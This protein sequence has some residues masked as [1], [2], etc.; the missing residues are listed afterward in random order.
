MSLEGRKGDREKGRK[1]HS[2][3]LKIC[4]TFL[5]LSLSPSLP[6][7]AEIV[8]RILAVVNDEIITQRE[9][10]EKAYPILLSLPAPPSDADLTQIR[11]NILVELVKSRLVVQAAKEKRILLDRQEVES[12]VASRLR[13]LSDRYGANVDEVLAEQGFSLAEFSDLLRREAKQELIKSRLIAQAVEGGVVVTDDEVRAEYHTRMILARSNDEALRALLQLKSGKL[14]FPEAV[15]QF[16]AGQDRD[17]G[18]DMGTYLLGKWSEEIE[19]EVIKLKTIGDLTG[20]IATPAGFAVVQLVERGLRP[21]ETI[22]AAD[23]EKIRGRLKALK[24]VSESNAYVSSLW[25]RA[26]IKFLD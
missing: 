5:P 6:S 23:R 8:D 11:R 26:Y 18:G 21:I 16:S 2:A 19:A 4:L 13:A 14:T 24:S 22:P 1:S 9:M 15:R 25:D 3:F 17:E 10:E 12:Y 20:V 7:Q